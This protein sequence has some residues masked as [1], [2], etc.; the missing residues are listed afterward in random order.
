MIFTQI[1]PDTYEGEIP[2]GTE[3]VV[4]EKGDFNTALILFGFDEIGMFDS[5]FT[6]PI[7]G[8]MSLGE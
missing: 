8:F 2:S 7:Y 4:M 1:N 5:K 3:L 6:T